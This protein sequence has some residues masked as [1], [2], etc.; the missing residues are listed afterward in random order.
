[1]RLGCELGYVGDLTKPTDLRKPDACPSE[2]MTPKERFYIRLF[3]YPNIIIQQQAREVFSI[4]KRLTF[5]SVVDIGCA[6]G[7]YATRIALDFPHS[8]VKGIDINEKQLC[9][10]NIVKKKFN[11]ENLTFEKRDVCTSLLDEKYDLVLLL[12]VIEHLKEDNVI[13]KKMRK[14]T[15]EHGHLII[16]TPNTESS[17]RNWAK[18]YVRIVGHCRDGYKIQDLVRMVMNS[19]FKIKKVKLLSGTLGNLAE[20]IE[21]YLRVNSLFLFALL[22]PF[23]DFLGFLDQHLK[24]KNIGSGILI[25]ATADR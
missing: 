7:Y 10:G 12:Q 23:L 14:M 15:H 21:I 1:M 11:I 9:I 3:G 25:L 24:A 2:P 13:L 17:I 18:K 22:Y 20:K 16:T 5:S 4:L 19:G 8:K 6:H